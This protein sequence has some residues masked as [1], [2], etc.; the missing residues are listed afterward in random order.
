VRAVPTVEGAGSADSDEDEDANVGDFS[1]LSEGVHSSDLSDSGVY[2]AGKVDI[3]TYKRGVTLSK[4]QTKGSLGPGGMG[5]LRQRMDMYES[6]NHL[7]PSRNTVEDAL[8]KKKVKDEEAAQRRK[9][10]PTAPAEYSPPGKAK[11]VPVT[12]TIDVLSGLMNSTRF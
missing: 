1:I 9:K 2:T 11:R 8:K 4:S 7:P 6:L 5:M 12:D 10:K 3:N